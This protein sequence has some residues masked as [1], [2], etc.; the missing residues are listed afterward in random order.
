MGSEGT[1]FVGE[2]QG[3]VDPRRDGGAFTGVVVPGPAR[4]NGVRGAW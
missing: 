1:A 4:R 2:G 3:R